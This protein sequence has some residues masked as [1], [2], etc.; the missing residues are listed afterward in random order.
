MK[1]YEHFLNT[2]GTQNEQLWRNSLGQYPRRPTQSGAASKKCG[3]AP[4]KVEL[5]P[6]AGHYSTNC[7]IIPLF[8]ELL[9]KK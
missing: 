5:V 8:V 7:G 2:F 3:T 6:K 1:T 4:Q 9:S